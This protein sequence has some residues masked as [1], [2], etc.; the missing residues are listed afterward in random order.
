MEGED[1]Q[2]LEVFQLSSKAFLWMKCKY[3]LMVFW[4]LVAP[5]LGLFLFFH[6]SYWYLLG[7]FCLFSL[8]LQIFSIIFKYALYTPNSDLS[9]NGLF[10]ALF[11][12]GFIMPFFLPLPFLMAVRY[13]RKAIHNLNDYLY[14]YH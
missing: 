1:R 12:M 11:S 10:I 5:L 14:A 4:S 3:Q 9:S 2:L 8:T 6:L 13:Y 7:Y